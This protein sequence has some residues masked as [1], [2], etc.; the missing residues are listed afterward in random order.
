M[1][2][3][4]NLIDNIFHMTD[5]ENYKTRL[6]EIKNAYFL[7]LKELKGKKIKILKEFEKVLKTKK[8]DRIKKDIGI[9]Q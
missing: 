9:N 5:S 7:G 3:C 1:L 8:I 6:T 2:F 4:D